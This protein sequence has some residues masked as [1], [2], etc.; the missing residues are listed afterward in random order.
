MRNKLARQTK[1]YTQCSKTAVI[2]QC[3]FLNENSFTGGWIKKYVITVWNMMN[4]I[5]D[6]QGWQLYIIYPS[7]KGS[8]RISEMYFHI[9]IILIFTAVYCQCFLDALYVGYY[10]WKRLKKK[11][12]GVVVQCFIARMKDGFRKEDL[13]ID[14]IGEST[15]NNKV[16]FIH[17]LPRGKPSSAMHKCKWI[18]FGLSRKYYLR[19]TDT[20][21]ALFLRHILLFSIM[22]PVTCSKKNL[23][24]S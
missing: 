23:R 15:S 4:T 1:L 16:S 8:D 20:V 17:F 22:I 11:D 21:N 12:L 9:Y 18:L 2:I 13:S 5:V 7:D 24:G 14:E 3:M 10:K 19:T 6:N